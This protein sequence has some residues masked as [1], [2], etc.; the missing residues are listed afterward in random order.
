MFNPRVIRFLP[1]LEPDTAAETHSLVSLACRQSQT[2]HVSLVFLTF[3]SSKREQIHLASYL[4]GVMGK[5][6]GA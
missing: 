6:V 3:T 2:L 5:A 1:V 4:M